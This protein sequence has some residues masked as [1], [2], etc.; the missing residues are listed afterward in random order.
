MGRERRK[1]TRVTIQFEVTVSLR[2]KKIKVETLNVSLTG[3]LCVSNPLFK[4][5]DLCKVTVDLGSESQ[6]VMDAK[7]LRTDDKVAAIAF[8]SMS[9]ESFFHL[10]K[11][12]QYNYGDADMIDAELKEPAF[13]T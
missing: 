4:Q 6:I 8:T 12:V 9:E 10:K 3:I 11:L 5:N 2:R 7:V 13:E 1:R